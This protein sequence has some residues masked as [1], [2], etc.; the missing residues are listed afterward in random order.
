MKM[1]PFS[2]KRLLIV[3]PVYPNEEGTYHGGVFVKDQVDVLKQHFREVIV[4]AP[5][6]RSFGLLPEDAFCSDYRYGNVQVYYPRAVYIPWPLYRRFGLGPLYYDTRC[7]AVERL[8]RQEEIEFD[9][10]HAH[11]TWP[12]ADIGRHLKEQ[13]GV[14]VVVTAHGYDAYELPFLNEI[15]EGRVRTVLNAADAIIT[16]SRKNEECIRSLGVTKPIHVIPNGFR[17]DLFYPRD[18]AECRRALGLP[19]DR[20]ILLAVGNLVEVKGH[21]YLVEAMAEVVK[22]RQDVLCVIVGSG[23]LKGRLEGQV[24]DLGLEEHVRFVGGRPHEEIPV[25]MNACD[26]FV[27]P[28]LRES[29]GIV[30]VE[31][32]ACGKPVV[33]TR[34]GGS[35]EILTSEETGYLVE[36][37]HLHSLAEKVNATLKKN[38]NDIF[39]AEYARSYTWTTVSTKISSLY[40][41][42]F[43]EY[44]C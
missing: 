41:T 10:V 28:S 36:S 39:I 11:F 5:V 7:R 38:W 30:Q 34:N 18:Q 29:F 43:P 25:W 35:E 31:A 17:S 3:T 16:V 6:L 32:M 20:K 8:I 14:P 1:A 40:R 27:L 22:E 33:A 26:V 19:M 42:M 15:W 4:I 24:R 37:A 21:R 9:L 12:S 44:D 2:E 13:Y 23:P